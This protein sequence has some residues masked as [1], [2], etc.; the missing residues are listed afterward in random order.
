MIYDVRQATIYHYATSVAYARHVL[1]LT[2]ID[3][4]DQ[5]VFAT[6]LDIDPEPIERREGWTSSVTGLRGSR[7]ISHTIRLTVR[8]AC[9]FQSTERETIGPCQH[10]AMGNVRQR[11][12][13][14][15]TFSPRSPA[16]YL[17]PSRQV[18]LDPEIRDYAASE[19]SPRPGILDGAIDLVRRI[20]RNSPMTW[21]HDCIDNAS[22][23]LRAPARR[24]SGLFTHHDFRFAIARAACG[25]CQRLS[26]N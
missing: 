2:P 21:S 1:R 7:L 4:P 10:P 14:P 12:R 16:H 20:T 23:G 6:A 5:R 11:V 18:S 3:R 25:L 8:V 19:L 26:A 22:D 24:V 17:F 13:L 15:R 9:E